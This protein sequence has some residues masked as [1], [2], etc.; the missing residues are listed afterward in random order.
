M[1]LP[2]NVDYGTVVGQFLLAYADSD[3]SG[4]QPDGIPAKGSIYF[5]PSPIKLLNGQSS[6]NPV[7]ILPAVVEC[8]LDSEGYLLGYPGDRGV[9]LVATD[10]ADLNPENWT[11]TVEFRLTDQDDVPVSLPSFSIALPK[12]TTVDLTTVTPVPDANGTYYLVG[13]TGPANELTVGTVSTLAPEQ[14]ATVTI[15]GTSPDQTINFGIPQG[16]AATLDV[17]STATVTPGTPASVTNSGTTADAIFD[18]EIPQGLAATVDAGTTTTVTPGTPA[19]VTNSGTTAEAVFDFEIPQGEAATVDVGTTTTSDPGTNAAVVNSGTTA[20]AVFD[21][22]IPRGDKGDAAT[23]AVG[24]TTTGDPGTSASVVN[25]GDTANAVFDFTIPE[26]IQGERG[27]GYQGITS[28]TSSAIGTG[29]KT[30]TLNK[31]DALMVGNRVRLA[32]ASNV[33]NFVEGLITG[34]SSLDITVNVDHSGGSGVIASWNIG[35][36]GARGDQGP[37]G[38]IESLTASAPV[39]YSSGNISF[40]WTSTILDDLGNVTFTSKTDADLIKWNN[41][42]SQ[43]ENSNVIDGGNA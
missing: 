3:D 14:N 27:F 16:E 5:R 35:I 13:P 19:S 40:D 6:P 43:W 20:E 18:F 39:V 31:I 41:A 17:G 7:T 38:S 10:D 37:T 32:D 28:A 2:S 42:S 26:G 15:T 34:I 4:S 30:F 8:Q 12:G 23:I 22:T 29:S 1:A 9:R 11:W 33:A 25:S 21:F 36:T 24:S